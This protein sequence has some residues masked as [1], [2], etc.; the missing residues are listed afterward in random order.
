MHINLFDR[1]GAATGADAR[2]APEFRGYPAGA[3]S[4]LADLGTRDRAWLAEHRT[5]Y[6]SLLTDP[7]KAL[8]VGLG[9][10]LQRSVSPALQAVPRVNGS[11]A[12][13]AN[14]RRFAGA[15]S[16]PPYRDSLLL[17]FWEGDDKPTAATLSVR[18]TPQ[19][20]EFAASR[21]FPGPLLPAYRA[22][23]AG[24][25]GGELRTA[26]TALQR[27]HSAAVDG[28]QLAR[29]PAGF[30]SDHPN[31][32]L[33]RHRWLRVRWAEPVPKAIGSA[34]FPKWCERRVVDL[35]DVH[36]WLRDR[37]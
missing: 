4:L 30:P 22:A 11:I 23:V 2:V 31:A 34:R 37:V 29:V 5:E 33:L 36:R 12:P 16:L 17:R 1:V 14:D 6:R 18:V 7:T 15:R 32:E 25:H 3:L 20:V 10:L 26:V 9:A 21:S 8:V 24:E 27:R 19:V 28:R 35:A 13:V